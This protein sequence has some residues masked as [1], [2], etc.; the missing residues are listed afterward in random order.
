M[1]DRLVVF[2]KYHNAVPLGFMVLFLSA[3][4]VLAANPELREAAADTVISSETKIKSVDNSFIV[5]TNLNDFTPTAQITDVREDTENYFI[6]Y[7]LNTIDLVDGVWGPVAQKKDLIISKEVIRGK[8]LGLHVAKELSEVTGRQS[9]YLGELQKKERGKGA[10]QKVLATTY[11]GLIGKLLDSKE[12][13]F[14]GYEPVVKQSESSDLGVTAPHPDT[15][16]ASTGGESGQAASVTSASSQQAVSVV[17]GGT[18]AMTPT[19]AKMRMVGANP[20]KIPTNATGSGYSDNGVIVQDDKQ[21]DLSYSIIVDG[22]AMQQAD[23]DTR[24]PGAHTVGYAASD[25]AGNTMALERVV[26]VY[27][28]YRTKGPA[29]VLSG[30]DIMTV[31]TGSVYQDAGAIAIDYDDGDITSK[32]TTQNDVNT[33]TA[34]TYAVKYSVADKDGN[35]AEA[36]RMITVLE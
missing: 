25:R 14:S 35:V 3:S 28:R 15:A 24:K 13:R 34:G 4:G 22:T 33:H 10:T 6:T 1:W 31:A 12:E 20:A 26:I 23:I 27:D 5:D 36:A 17:S 9:E 2:V 29:L 21:V 11:S 30:D 32:I 18:E 19:G 16:A 8:D 7:I